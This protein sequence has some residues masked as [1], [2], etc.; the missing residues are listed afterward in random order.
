VD[1][2]AAAPEQIFIGAR[3]MH[4]KEATFYLPAKPEK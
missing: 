3:G 4:P 1:E 2:Q